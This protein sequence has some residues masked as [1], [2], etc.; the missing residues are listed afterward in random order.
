MQVCMYCKCIINDDRP[1]TV[2]DKCGTKV[3]GDKMFNAIKQNMTDARE[4]GDLCHTC[5]ITKKT[6]NS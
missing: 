3:W 6:D 1:I 5:S 2:C 4:K